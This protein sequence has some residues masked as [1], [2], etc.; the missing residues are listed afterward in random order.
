MPPPSSRGPRNG[1]GDGNG[2]QRERIDPDA[3]LEA[4]LVDVRGNKLLSVKQSLRFLEAVAE[5]RIAG[6]TDALL[7]SEIRKADYQAD[8][9]DPPN[10]AREK[11]R[12]LLASYQA[13]A[14]FPPNQ[15]RGS[16]GHILRDL[17]FAR[18]SLAKMPR[19][20]PGDE[21]MALWRAQVAWAEAHAGDLTE[22][23]SWPVSAAAVAAGAIA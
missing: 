2:G 1:D 21:G 3:A 13:V 7:A 17:A 15:Q 18:R 11:A 23:T 5:A 10:V 12:R 14:R 8:V 19:P 4:L 20:D 6:A 22:S 9:W 16:I